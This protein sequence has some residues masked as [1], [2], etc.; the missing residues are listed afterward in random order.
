MDAHLPDAQCQEKP[1]RTQTVAYE[2]RR[3]PSLIQQSQA[4]RVLA[5]GEVLTPK[6]VLSWTQSS[7]DTSSDPRLGLDL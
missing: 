5:N 3:S 7:D 6:R 1:Y 4:L 2:E